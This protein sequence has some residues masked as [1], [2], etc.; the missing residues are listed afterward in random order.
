V[1][2]LLRVIV[3]GAT[4]VAAIAAFVRAIKELKSGTQESGTQESG[5]QESGTQ[6]SGTQ[7]AGPA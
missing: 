2:K 4:A 6:E 5:A 1:G 3:A 7:E